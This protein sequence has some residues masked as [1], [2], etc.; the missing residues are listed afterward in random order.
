MLRLE[1]TQPHY[2]RC[3]KPN[4][5]GTSGQLDQTY[6]L[7]QLQACG[8]IETVEISRQAFPAR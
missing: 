8:I 6:V 7:T 5:E 2:V 1:Q 3:M 4:A